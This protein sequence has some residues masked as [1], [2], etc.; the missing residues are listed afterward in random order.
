M[1]EAVIPALKLSEAELAFLKTIEAQM[2]I[3]ADLSRADILLY[4]QRSPQEAIVLAHARPHSLAHVYTKSREGRVV[5]RNRRPEVLQA[6]IAG[7]R[8]K[9]FRSFI[10]EGAPVIR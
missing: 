4:G 7:K 5:D 1:Y 9:E 6:L 2:G 8:Q 10:A 3:V